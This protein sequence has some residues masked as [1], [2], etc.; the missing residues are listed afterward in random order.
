M[1]FKT[2]QSNSIAPDSPEKLFLDLPR[3]KIPGVLP[4][5][6][7]LMHLY[8]ETA[9]NEPDVAL[10]LPTG[11]GKTLVGLLI[12]EWRR[13]KF[14]EK[15]V[16]L[17]ST[18]QL[19]NQVVEQAEEKYGLTV[20]KFIGSSK[21]YNPVAKADYKS[22]AAIAVTTY[23]GLFNS[24]PYFD[25]ADVI[26]LD[27]VHTAENYISS[28]WSIKIER[29]NPEHSSLHAALSGLIKPLVEPYVYAR[30]TGDADGV[31]DRSWVD[32]L[33]TPEFISIVDQITEIM[34]VY[35]KNSQLIHSWKMISDRLH[36]CHLYFS[37][38]EILIRPLIPPTW[39]H[40]PFANAKQRIYMSATLGEGG[41]LERLV[42]RS[43]IKRLPVSSGWDLHGVGRR[44]F[45]FPEMSLNSDEVKELRHELMKQTDRSLVL[46]PN[47]KLRDE[48]IDDIHTNLGYK[49]FNVDDIE[50]TKSSF[51][52]TSQ[53]IAVV[54]NRYD[55]I[56]F[57]GNECRLLFIEGLPKATNL[58]ER[59]L[60][61]RMGANAIF[62]ERIQTRVLQS[63]GRCTRSLEDYS[64]VIVSGEELPDYLA[65]SHRRRYFH[66][67][68]QAELTFG[69]EQSR[70][71]D[72]KGI[73]DNLKI[74][75][76]NGQE[77]E[78]VSQ[79]IVTL[80]KETS[81]LQFPSMVELQKTVG[82]EITYQKK[83]WQKDYEAALSSADIVLSNIKSPELRGYRALWHYLAGSAAMLA[84]K[85]GGNKALGSR[86]RKEYSQAKD[87]A[88]GIT[89]LVSLSRYSGA[90]R[91]E[92][93]INDDIILEQIERLETVLE[94]LGTTY[95]R[96]YTE[97]E[98]EIISG[99]SSSNAYTFENAHKLLGIMLGF[100]SD[101]KETD[102]A[103]DPWWINSNIC[104]VFEDHSSADINS[105]ISITKARQAASHPSWMR[106]NVKAASEADILPVLITPVSTVKKS[107]LVY[108]NDVSLWNLKDF[109]DWAKGALS[110]I[111]ELRTSFTETGDL[112]WRS[113]AVSKL[114]EKGYDAISLINKLKKQ[115]AKD[116]LKIIN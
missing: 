30:L 103:P 9:L 31:S 16:Y 11:S 89:W 52:N 109:Q 59:F 53:A 18:K 15:I 91:N 17:A 114:K 102:G 43:P 21:E 49:V 24:N 57:P 23:S 29:T 97:R 25:D 99:L 76:E 116:L 37:S 39:T 51:I 95:Q 96:K 78:K 60:M 105:A 8:T 66:P 72:S 44:F 54:A 22:G 55:G 84:V 65:D 111:R 73:V 19:V 20:H 46:V 6:Q 33:P 94:S 110:T 12:G 3:R 108:L 45:I 93:E 32:K 98:N 13:K 79:Q 26:I 47:N 27:D 83:I 40:E 106:E 28:L 4:H 113:S 2:I 63:I 112:S 75:L 80:R 87:A 7:E 90:E 10:Q 38:Q 34:D 85:S 61:S 50:T 62:N 67:E 71:I 58:Q 48:I 36:A 64:A 100:N 74:F 88:T 1:A 70:N 14:G 115:R 42:G 81:K 5:Q 107:A 77:W 68:L 86:V 101:N 82:D 69:I 92:S 41:D 56:D 104:L 35:T